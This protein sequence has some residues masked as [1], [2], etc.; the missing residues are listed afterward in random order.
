MKTLSFILLCAV[1]LSCGKK[2]VNPAKCN[3]YIARYQT[4]LNAYAN[5][6]T[7]AN[8]IAVRNI[9]GDIV[10]KCSLLSAKERDEYKEDLEQMDCN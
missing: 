4:T 9:L 7:P 3:E 6:P 10:D 8:C 1:C 2:A 5:N